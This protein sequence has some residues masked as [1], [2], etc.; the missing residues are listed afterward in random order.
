MSGAWHVIELNLYE[1]YIG[2]YYCPPS[3]DEETEPQ[4][5]T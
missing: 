3:I 4:K 2:G 5:R 1:N